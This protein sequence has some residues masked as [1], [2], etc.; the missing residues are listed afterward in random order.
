MP[1]TGLEIVSLVSAILSF[2]DF[3]AKIVRGTA[4]ILRSEVGATEQNTHVTNVVADLEKV[5]RGL[6]THQ[7]AVKDADLVRLAG[8][9]EALSVEL[10]QLLQNLL[11]KNTSLPETFKASLKAWRKQPKVAEM[12]KRLGEYRSQVLLRLAF[13]AL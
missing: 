6:K 3:S 9:C 8:Q 1:L 10:S 4:E 2:I 11:P 7:Q 5:T 12:E 13:I